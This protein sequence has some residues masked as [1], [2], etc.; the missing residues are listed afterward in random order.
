MKSVTTKIL[1]GLLSVLMLTMVGS[2]IYTR[3]NDNHDTEEAVLCDISENIPFQ[4]VIVRDETIVTYD[5][6]GVLDYL[7]ADGSKV[8]VDN[9]IAEVYSSEDA[10]AAKHKAEKLNSRIDDLERAQ[11]PGTTNYVQPETLKSK[12]DDQY[13]QLL[14]YSQERDFESAVKLKSDMSVVINIYNIITDIS[15]NYDS[16]ISQLESTASQLEAQAGT[17]DVIN[18]P[19]TG[20]FVSYC[21][22]YEDSLSVEFLSSIT[23]QEIE[24]VINNASSDESGSPENAIGKMF[25]DYSCSIVGVVESDKRIIEGDTLQIMFSTS[26]NV[27]DVTVESVRQAEEDGKSII[28]LSC[29][30]LDETLVQSRV[31][32]VELIF[33]EY[34]GIKVPRKA[35][36]FQG[37]QKGVY[38]I[39][40]N[41]ITFK[42]IDVIYEG[43]DFMI[44]ENTSDEEYLLLYDQI[45]LEVV[46]NKDVSEINE[47]S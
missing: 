10:I 23:Q 13:R 28:V 29:D 4:G 6:E 1:V 17:P 34:H 46:S 18:A 36:R 32:S 26:N 47:S 27:Y 21:D 22:G 37:E 30:R 43:D 14:T 5:G 15:K 12:I 38:V 24:D 3:L 25:D 16:K 20:Y 19:E 39:L 40:G 35:I 33:E 7:Y 31:Q 8:S 11:N 41:E 9:P 45:L 2:Q 44:S 42:K